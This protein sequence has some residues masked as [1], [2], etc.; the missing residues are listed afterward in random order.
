MKDQIA[1][2]WDRPDP[3]PKIPAQFDLESRGSPTGL[4]D[5]EV[6]YGAQSR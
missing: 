3:S 2:N 5:A 6:A 4:D 1:Q